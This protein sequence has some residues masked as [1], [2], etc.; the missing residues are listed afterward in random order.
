MDSNNNDNAPP[1]QISE[2]MLLLIGPT[3]VG[4]TSLLKIINNENQKEE[5][6]PTFGGDFCL[7][8]FVFNNAIVKTSIIEISGMDQLDCFD[9]IY[10]N[11]AD[12]VIF[13]FDLSNKQSYKKIMEELKSYQM[14]HS[15]RIRYFL[16]GNKNDLKREID[17]QEAKAT[18]QEN[19]EMTYYEVTIK[20]PELIR[21]AFEEIVLKILESKESQPIQRH[22]TNLIPIIIKPYSKEKFRCN[23][24]CIVF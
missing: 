1:S 2:C 9:E 23:R 24:K 13:L 12:G 16:L 6:S 10:K 5:I 22:N 7:R 3:G 15:N 11:N 20:T 14:V 19:R 8:D 4:K 18:A 21:R 17:Y